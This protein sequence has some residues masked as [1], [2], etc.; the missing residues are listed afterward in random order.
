MLRGW[1]GHCFRAAVRAH[2][3]KALDH[4][5]PEVIYATWAYPEGWAAV[6]LA[7]E[8]G[9]PVAVKV[10]GSDILLL[11]R[12]GS[13]RSRTIEALTRADAVIA[14]SHHLAAQI[15]DFGIN[16]RRLSVVY[17]GVYKSLFH[18]EQEAFDDDA[19]P[20][21]LYVGNLLPVKVPN[22]LVEACDRL[23]KRNVQFD[24]RSIVHG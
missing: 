2:F 20:L 19:P 1:Y 16:P 3:M 14:V 18:I 7:R 21:L 6:E 5:Q 17:N 11:G 15:T 13:R 4:F 8:A 10:H 24:C 9:L 12:R 22:V 23:T